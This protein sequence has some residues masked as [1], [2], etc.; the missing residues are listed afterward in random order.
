MERAGVSFAQEKYM[1]HVFI[2]LKDFQN[3]ENNSSRCFNSN[4]N[5]LISLIIGPTKI[6]E[7]HVNTHAIHMKICTKYMKIAMKYTQNTHENTHEIGI[8][9]MKM[10]MKTHMKIHTKYTKT[11]TYSLRKPV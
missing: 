6:H 2:F 11:H 9:Y 3:E 5:N 10:H 1:L 7:V 8:K 4:I